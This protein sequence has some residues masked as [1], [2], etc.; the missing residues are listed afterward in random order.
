MEMVDHI[1]SGLQKLQ[2]TCN[3]ISSCKQ[4]LWTIQ[5]QLVDVNI[6]LTVHLEQAREIIDV[7]NK[8]NGGK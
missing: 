5:Q 6:D 1:K 7:L 2:K 3:N 4:K 8:I